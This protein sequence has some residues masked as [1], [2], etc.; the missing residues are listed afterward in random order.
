MAS[1]AASWP[2]LI[3]HPPTVASVWAVEKNGTKLPRYSPKATARLAMPPDIT[4]RNDAHPKRK[5]HSGP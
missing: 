1:A 4:T 2:P 3:R 5:P